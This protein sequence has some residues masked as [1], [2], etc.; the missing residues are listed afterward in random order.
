MS[1]DPTGAG[2]NTRVMGLVVTVVIL[3]VVLVGL[4]LSMGFNNYPLF[5]E[6][7]NILLVPALYAVF[8]WAIE[9]WKFLRSTDS[10]LE[11][12][13]V[14]TTDQANDIQKNVSLAIAG[15][16]PR[17][18]EVFKEEIQRMGSM[19]FTGIM[20]QYRTMHVFG[21]INERPKDFELDHQLYGDTKILFIGV[22]PHL[23]PSFVSKDMR[24]H[25][26]L[27]TRPKRYQILH[28]SSSD[29]THL[30]FHSILDD[31]FD[32]NSEVEYRA[33]N[34]NGLKDLRE[35]LGIGSDEPKASDVYQI[36]EH[37]IFPFGSMVAHGNYIWYAPLWNHRN[38]KTTGAALEVRRDSQFGR[39]L[40][41][42][43][44]AIWDSAAPAELKN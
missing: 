36:V 44:D 33:R 13:T 16:E 30:R 25:A 9:K 38:S 43:F 41:D 2:R 18:N 14:R 31:K 28:T 32:A 15:H 35:M 10:F 7:G 37:R 4:L 3:S 39:E 26:K 23:L 42:S 19:Y 12:L 8:T 34:S 21:E 27:H 22:A 11:K 40:I 29:V 20:R 24:E 6:W 17:V 1:N 5:R